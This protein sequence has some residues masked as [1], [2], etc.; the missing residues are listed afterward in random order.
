MACPCLSAPRAPHA[1]R[2]D[3]AHQ[4]SAD[5]SAL[6]LTPPETRLCSF[7]IYI[8]K[9][10]IKIEKSISPIVFNISIF[11]LVKINQFYKLGF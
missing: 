5:R 4:V 8:I 10:T 2:T 1:P 7:N 6:C 9:Q 3:E 11:L